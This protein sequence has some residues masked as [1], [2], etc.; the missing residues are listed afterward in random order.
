VNSTPQGDA[1]STSLED[2]ASSRSTTEMQ[3]RTAPSR[4][5]EETISLD[6]EATVIETTS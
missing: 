3:A 5:S 2:A 1:K 6:A 4:F